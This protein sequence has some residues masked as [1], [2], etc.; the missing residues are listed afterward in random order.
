[1]AAIE[2]AKGGSGIGKDIIDKLHIH[3]N[4]EVIDKLSDSSGKLLYNG[5]EIITE[6]SERS[7]SANYVIETN[8]RKFVTSQQSEALSGIK[9][10]I[11]LKI[12]VL[13]NSLLET[14]KYKG[15]YNSYADMIAACVNPKDGWTTFIESDETQNS[16]KTIYV[17]SSGA[18]QRARKDD[19]ANGWVASRTQPSNTSVL[20]LDTSLST[21]LIK[22]YN[23]VSWLT[24]GGGSFTG[25][26]D[27]SKVNQ[28]KDLNFVTD[29]S[30]NILSKLVI[31]SA[32]GELMF[33][34]EYLGGT[35]SGT[36]LLDD[37]QVLLDKTYSSK[38]IV[39]LLN[40]KQGKLS[41]MPEDAS[42]KGVAGGYASLD[43][44]GKIPETQIPASQKSRNYVVF[45]NTERDS[46]S[47]V[48][49]GEKCYVKSTGKEY[50][51]IDDIGWQLIADSTSL[52]TYAKNNLNAQSN[53]TI[54][55]DSS[56][57]YNVGSIWINTSAKKAYVCTDNTKNN[58]VWDMMAGTNSTVITFGE[59]VPFVYHANDS[60]R[61]SNQINFLIPKI[62]ITKDYIEVTVDGSEKIKDI[63]YTIEEANESYY[64]KFN[65]EILPTQSVIGEIYKYN[66]ETGVLD[67]MRK[68]EY[69]TNADGKIDLAELSDVAKS[70]REFAENTSYRKND[71]V[72]KDNYLYLAKSNFTSGILFDENNWIKIYAKL[73]N[74]NGFTTADLTQA[75]EFNFLS[76]AEKEY[77][78]TIPTLTTNVDKANNAAN[79][80]NS[81]VPSGT[82]SSNKLVNTSQ[83][84]TLINS[85]KFTDL[86]DTPN[87]L[88]ANSFLKVNSDGTAI[89]QV[90]EPRFPI[91]KITDS[92]G[93]A[94]TDIENLSLRNLEK[95]SF[96]NGELVLKA[97]LFSTE[98]KDMPI[99]IE[100][101]KVLVGNKDLM[102]YEFAS[103]GDLTVSKENFSVNINESSW[104]RDENNRYN[105]VITHGL[106]SENLIISCTNQ[107]KESINGITY[108]VIDEDNVR[109]FTDTPQFMKCVINCSLGVE[110]G[111]W[112]N[113]FDFSKFSL[114]DDLRPRTDKSYSSI[115]LESMLS[116]YV[117]KA[118]VYNKAES[119]FR[120]AF[121]NLE[122]QHENYNVLIGFK[123]DNE[124]N[125]LFE[126]KKLL[127]EIKPKMYK[128][129]LLA[130]SKPI[131][132]KIIDT[133]NIFN[134]QGFQTITAS[135][136]LIKNTAT[137]TGNE[138]TDKANALKLVIK[139]GTLTLLDLIIFP[140]EVQKYQ[141]GISPNTT[142]H[143]QGN[144]DLNYY[145]S[146]F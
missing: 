79:L 75:K 134:T 88:S 118:N 102:R 77:V 146:A 89:Q 46:L 73:E 13:S 141:L 34:G 119:D 9:D 144:Y 50:I 140:E 97:K 72:L 11:Q 123:K 135:E 1:M 80:L 55:D 38:K 121:K 3:D 56:L 92:S 43:T 57:G 40:N 125:I 114:I 78:K 31:D 136:I 95:V 33:D 23:G 116:E 18:W 111:Y 132:T 12:N 101:G 103:V 42:K 24:I 130:Q 47:G 99:D 51:Y 17:Y 21:P 86:T 63:D 120:Y 26:I 139:D 30:K 28:Q 2:F 49:Q 67:N 82:S 112:T 108:K 106:G 32:T 22:W 128:E 35:G 100:H 117:N 59:I 81:F 90:F 45:N 44:N 5:K 20:W 27:A 138:A 133:F 36:T 94:F 60:S 85:R 53:P 4:K 93:T 10:N 104:T 84:N 137:K 65:T 91:K 87:V 61:Q 58:A 66:L 62:D 7:I 69:D 37:N 76:F 143:V 19:S 48:V 8:S 126:N 29:D 52:G 64:I 54:S 109:I 122:H 41:Y 25:T 14:M 15:R 6:T 127:T 74:L 105:F 39:D 131:L 115:K 83:M 124:G 107:L 113:L 70:L 110:N 145:V 16:A 142:V 129:I 98:L 68:S 71:L 96:E